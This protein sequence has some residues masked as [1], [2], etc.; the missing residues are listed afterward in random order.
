M[1]SNAGESKKTCLNYMIYMY[2]YI[3]V[4][5]LSLDAYTPAVNNNGLVPSLLLDPHDLIDEIY[6]PNPR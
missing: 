1:N 2:V 6:H 4:Q 5:W 3:Q